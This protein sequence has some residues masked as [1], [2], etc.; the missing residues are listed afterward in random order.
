MILSNV[1]TVWRGDEGLEKREEEAHDDS[2][3]EYLHCY[4]YILYKSNPI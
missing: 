3:A 2:E 1:H 4:T